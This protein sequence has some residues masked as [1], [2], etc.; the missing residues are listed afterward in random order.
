[1]CVRHR[2]KRRTAFTL[3]QCLILVILLT[4]IGAIV[5]PMI[6]FGS[7]RGPNRIGQ[8]GTQLKGIHNGMILYSQSNNDYF[9]GLNSDGTEA[10][11]VTA[12]PTVK[13]S[14]G[15][16][17][18]RGYDPAARYAILLNNGFF[19]P[20]FAVSPLDQKEAVK[21]GG[22][23][24]SNHFSYAMLRLSDEAATGRRS[25]WRSNFNR[26]FPAA[27]D[28]NLSAGSGANAHSIFSDGGA[29]RGH[30]AWNDNHVEFER[31]NVLWTTDSNRKPRKPP[32]LGWDDLFAD[33]AD[34][35]GNAGNDAAMVFQDAD[36]YTNQK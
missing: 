32:G 35:D 1:M 6:D 10:S 29:W 15:S 34:P 2:R 19:T 28:R 21:P 5:I 26:E 12:D 24:N 33:D 17:G 13:V 11:A 7:R 30:V 22:D 31:S 4:A 3:I 8:S 16:G 14:V 36:T 23:I 9:P 18:R 27:S 25:M 20:E